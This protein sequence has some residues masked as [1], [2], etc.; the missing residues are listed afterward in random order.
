MQLNSNVF[1]FEYRNKKLLKQFKYFNEF[2]KKEINFI[3]NS[4]KLNITI[5]NEIDFMFSL[6]ILIVLFTIEVF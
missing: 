1:N 3:V 2:W 6:N 5:R 4:L